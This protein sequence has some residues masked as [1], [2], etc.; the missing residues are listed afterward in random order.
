L[1][2]TLHNLLGSKNLHSRCGEL[3]RQRDAVEVATQSH[4]SAN[5]FAI[6]QK[7]WLR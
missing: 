5:V 3:K 6:N 1:F 2:E 7:G 4:D